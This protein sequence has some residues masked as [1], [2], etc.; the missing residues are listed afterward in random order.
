MR[1]WLALAAAVLA[2]DQAVKYLIVQ[3]FALYETLYVLPVF[4]LTRLHNTGAAFSMFHDAGGWQRWFFIAVAL[5]A[6]L[7]VVWLLRRHPQDTLFCLALALILGGAIGNLTDRVLY[8]Y[9]VDFL[10]V[11]YAGHF[12]PAFNVADSAITV[13]AGLMIWEGFFPRR[14]PPA[15]SQAD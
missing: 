6:S 13:G 10:Q 12:F 15:S 8:G 11:H 9:V 5:G 14:R 7:W 1:K 4:N 2:A 3:R